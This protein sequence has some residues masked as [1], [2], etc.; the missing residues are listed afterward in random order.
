MIPQN[1]ISLQ[2]IKAALRRRFWYV[3]IPF[4]VISISSVVYCIWAPKTYRSISLILIQPQEV[5]KDYVKTTVTSKVKARLNAITEKIMSRSRLEAL[6]KEYDIY[7]EARTAVEMGRAVAGMRRKINIIF[8]VGSGLVERGGFD[9]PPAF[10]VSFEGKD[11]AKVR[12]VTAALASMFIDE[13]LRL[14]E[15]QAGGTSNFLEGEV[16]RMREVLRQKEELVRQFREKHTG[17]LPE[18][19]ED[20]YRILAQLQQHLDSVNLSLQQT[21]DR[22]LLLQS[23][24]DG[25][26]TMQTGTLEAGAS[27]MRPA[28]DQTPLSLEELRQQLQT[29]RER[30]SDKHPDV[31]RLSATLEKREKE[32]KEPSRET[33]SPGRN[34]SPHFTRSQ[35]IIQTRGENLLTQFK[36]LDKEIEKLKME[37]ESTSRQLEEYR[38]RIEDGPRIEQMFVDLRRDYETATQNYQNILQKKLEADL[39]RNLEHTQ[40]GEQF[41][42]QDPANFPMKPFKPDIFK[43]M[44]IGLLLAMTIGLGLAHLREYMDPTFWT[45]R[46][47][48]SAFELPVLVSIPVIQTQKERRWKTFKL[49]GSVCVL[50]L[51]GSVLLFA[52]FVLWRENPG[53]LPL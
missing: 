43:V 3:V 11:P 12:D 6:I 29:L 46:D 15:E 5:P 50:I 33:D 26:E 45:I 35:R 42:I 7:P 13:N 36:L 38:N 51:M 32:I 27:Q 16:E 9:S 52:M 17:F 2:Y 8:R 34:N 10:G 28:D 25:I 47:L 19:K 30:Y 48:E 49:A 44:G 41:K 4:F 18:Q 20:N 53:L 31:R 14:R 24:I 1:G 37:R 22:K 40:K 39:A 21:E 23:Q